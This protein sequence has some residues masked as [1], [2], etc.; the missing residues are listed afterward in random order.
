MEGTFEMSQAHVN[1]SKGA[2]DVLVSLRWS[3]EDNEFG[4]PGTIVAMEGKRGTGVHASLSRFDLRNILVAAGPDIKSGFV[5][6]LPSGNIDLAPTVLFLLGVKPERE[7]DGRVLFE[8]LNNS[9]APALKPIEETLSAERALG[10]LSWR[11]HLKVVK[12]GY[13]TYY[14]EGNGECRLR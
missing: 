4:A 7:M 6:E 9:N 12:V 13:A 14:D 11:Q 8:A 5:S 1:V 10:F 2:P 3:S